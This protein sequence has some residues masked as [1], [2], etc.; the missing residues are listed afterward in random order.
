MLRRT[1]ILVTLILGS[2]L[3]ETMF[4]MT[5]CATSADY[6][7]PAPTVGTIW[8]GGVQNI[9]SHYHIVKIILSWPAVA[10][11][12]RMKHGLVRADNAEACQVLT[13][14]LCPGETPGG[15]VNCSV[16][17]LCLRCT[18]VPAT[19][20]LAGHSTDNCCPVA[21]AGFA[22]VFAVVFAVSILALCAA[23]SSRTFLQQDPAADQDS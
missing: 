14:K 13:R 12:G 1:I 11:L 23:L 10:A 16:C 18:T 19:P 7:V 22:V 3:C 5:L 15:T 4:R 20:Y 8:G 17:P 2:A 21:T 6:R 9:T